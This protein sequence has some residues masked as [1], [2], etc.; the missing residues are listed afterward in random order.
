[1]DEGEVT[2]TLLASKQD[3]EIAELVLEHD[4]I[5]NAESSAQKVVIIRIIV[6]CL[7]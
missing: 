3:G 5:E 4:Q 6:K 1:M 7:N 2:L